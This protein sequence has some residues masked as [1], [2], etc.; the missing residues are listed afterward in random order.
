VRLRPLLLLA[1]LVLGGV[2]VPHAS[3]A[4]SFTRHTDA[5]LPYWV[6]VPSSY[7]GSTEVPLVV[8]LQGCNQSVPDAAQGSRWNALA[9]EKGFLVAYPE[10]QVGAYP[11]QTGNV[12]RCWNFASPLEWS[13]TAFEPSSIATIT[14]KVIADLAVDTSRVYVTGVSAGGAMASNMAALYPE[15]YSAAGVLLG[16]S[17]PCGDATGSGAYNAMAG[18]AR[19]MPVFNVIGVGDPA[20]NAGV[21]EVTV[22]QWLS[23]NDFVDDGLLNGSVSQTPAALEQHGFDQVPS[24]GTGDTCIQPGGPSKLP[25]AGGVV[26]LTSYP[27]TVRRYNDAQGDLLDYWIIYGLDHAY[28]GGDPAASFTDPAGPDVTRAA[29]EFFMAHPR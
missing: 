26:G 27:Y 10:Q 6:Y 12:S 14:S 28:P 8:Y 24:P 21:G 15:L 25:C 9:E 23:T 18:N 17:F 3:A 20:I 11:A 22:M 2:A 1:A 13:R 19:R 4:S 29:Y 7:D 16:C 5:A